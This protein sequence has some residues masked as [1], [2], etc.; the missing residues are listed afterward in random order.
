MAHAI[1]AGC[2]CKRKNRAM[3]TLMQYV[4]ANKLLPSKSLV[5]TAGDVISIINA[6]EYNPHEGSVFNNAKIR[7]GERVCSGDVVL[8][9][10]S[11]DWEKEL[12][13]KKSTYKNVILHVTRNDDVE[14]IR[15]HGESVPQL[16]ITFAPQLEAEYNDV[17]K[18]GAQ[19]P[20]H[21]TIS[22]MDKI[23][24]HANLSRLLVERIEEKA[25]RINNLYEQCDKRWDDT[26]FKLL[27]RNFG[28][29]IQ[30]NAFELWASELNMQALAKHRDNELQIEAIF[31]GQAGL[32]ESDTIPAYYRAEAEKSKYYN[33]LK[34]EYKFLSGKFNL[35]SVDAKIWGTGNFTPHMRIARLATLYA[36]NNVS[37]SA[38]AECDTLQELRHL[39][40]VQPEGYWRNHL[41]FGGTET[42]GTGTLK[43]SQTDLLI[44]NTVAPIL[45]TYGKHRN[46]ANLCE[47]A[48]DFLH[49]IPGENNSIIRSW[50]QMGV[51]VSCAADSQALIH[52]RKNYC[53]KHKCAE[54]R[55]AY[56]Y[57]KEKI[58][59]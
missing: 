35:K 51:N 3:D 19:L 25:G 57:F 38:I 14:T 55:F 45:Y 4:W 16:Q 28:F 7:I 1:F 44:I 46:D 11:S 30:G 10:K 36:K 27:A 6:G 56:A 42:I 26:L 20:C 40:Q 32:L 29:G 58:R 59:G 18:N 50:N 31:F 49:T 9:D 52:L 54:C 13:D 22:E 2:N 34:R 43:N 48:E 23:E 33:D 17:I 15:P 5:T 24:L 41:I 8:H 53:N 47:K 39:L 21:G 12:H 37:L